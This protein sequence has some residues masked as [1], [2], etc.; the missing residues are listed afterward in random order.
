[1]GEA[2]WRRE[3]VVPTVYHHTSSL[4]TNLIW[5]SGVI[6]VEGESEGAVHPELGQIRTDAT[7][8]RGLHD[9][10]PVAWFTK[11]VEVPKCLQS[12]TLSCVSDDTG[13]TTHFEGNEDIANAIALH[14]VALGFPIGA[15]AVVPWPDYIGY[16]TDEGRRL[17][18]AA[19]DV[20]DD[21]NDWY[22]SE[23]PVDVLSATEIYRSSSIT[24]PK[25][26]RDQLYLREVHD[27]VRF[28]RENPNFF[29]PP[30]W[31]PAKL[32]TDLSKTLGVPVIWA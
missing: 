19:Q 22:V 28:C 26:R 29:L 10:P 2:K 12:L 11:R 6:H 18:D 9:F 27:T 7:L 16:H 17:N 13:E 25:L 3:N 21:P 31:M 1:M 14:R 24:E 5:M 23:Q 8:R 20:G 4:R 32:N 30:T 15:I